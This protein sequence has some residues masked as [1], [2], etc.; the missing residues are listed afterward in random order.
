MAG[1]PRHRATSRTNSLRGFLCTVRLVLAPL[2]TISLRPDGD[3]ISTSSGTNLS[4]HSL[5][6][7]VAVWDPITDNDER[8]MLMSH[9]GSP[10]RDV[11]LHQ[12]KALTPRIALPSDSQ[13]IRKRTGVLRR[14][15]CSGQ[16]SHNKGVRRRA[17]AAT[18][19][20]FMVMVARVRREV[21]EVEGR[22]VQNVFE[23][24]G[25]VSAA[26]ILLCT[27]DSVLWPR[28][29]SRPFL[30]N[31]LSIK[32]SKRPATSSVCTR[33]ARELRTKLKFG[34]EAL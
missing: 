9:H 27:L 32:R 20:S 8:R 5:S 2:I 18:T 29:S 24:T 16:G 26:H 21:Q 23:V 4:R 14:R 15:Q 33:L 31:I 28:S 25:Q 13:T 34:Q 19:G 7:R 11:E 12:T 22:S 6:S 10:F 3:R 1:T 30:Q 17:T